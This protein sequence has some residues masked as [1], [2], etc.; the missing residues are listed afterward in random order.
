MNWKPITAKKV[1]RSK[2]S[3]HKSNRTGYSNGDFHSYFGF[4]NYSNF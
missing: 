2:E 3:H 4:H 1:F